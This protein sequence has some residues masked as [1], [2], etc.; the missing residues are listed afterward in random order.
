MLSTQSCHLSCLQIKN[1]LCS[2]MV[3]YLE[4]D[5]THDMNFMILEV[6]VVMMWC[7]AIINGLVALGLARRHLI[8]SNGVRSMMVTVGVRSLLAPAGVR[9]PICEFQHYGQKYWWHTEHKCIDTTC[10]AAGH[11]VNTESSSTTNCTI[12]LTQYI[13][14]FHKNRSLNGHNRLTLLKKHTQKTRS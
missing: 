10:T 1:G 13:I 8:G 4:M 3:L 5:N 2:H 11:N 14:I 6:I 12:I 7:I 9:Y